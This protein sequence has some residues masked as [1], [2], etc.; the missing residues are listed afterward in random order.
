MYSISQAA[1]L[2]TLERVPGFPA[3]LLFYTVQGSFFM[4][5]S[6]S[7]I[8]AGWS[9]PAEPCAQLLPTKVSSAQVQTGPLNM[10]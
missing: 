9:P 3:Y 1:P 5:T 7:S 6:L 4:D 2:S 10:V 8:T